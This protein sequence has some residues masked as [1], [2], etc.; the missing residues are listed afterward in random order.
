[1]EESKFIKKLGVSMPFAE[2]L[3]GSI[4][5]F[6][7][8]IAVV[9][10]GYVGLPLAVEFGKKYQTVGFDT[11]E[12]RI[13]ALEKG[14]DRTREMSASDL[15]SAGMLV[16]SN[17]EQSIRECRVYIVSVP[18]PIDHN[19]IPDLS[20][21][22]S[23]SSLVGRSLQKGDVVV[24]ESTVYPG[25]TEEV[26]VPILENTSELVFNKDFFVGYSPERI[27]PGDKAHRLVDIVKVTSGSTSEAARFVDLLYQSVISAGTY[28]AESIKVAEAAKVIENTQR[29]L[30]IALVNELSMIF[31]KQKIDTKAVLDAAASK[32]NFMRFE[33]GLVGGHCIGVDPYY[34]TYKAQQLGYKPEVILAG[35]R[36]NDSMA[37]YVV[38]L[39]VRA[40]I[41]QKRHVKG[42]R[43]LVLGIAFKENCG[44]IRNTKVIDIIKGFEDL[45]VSV[46]IFDPVVDQKDVKAEFGLELLPSLES[47]DYDFVILAVPHDE[48]VAV[49]TEVVKSI[50][51]PG[52]IIFDIKGV[53]PR[54]KVYGRL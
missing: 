27:N 6:K 54:D 43:A 53:W 17:D 19:N 1:M 29:D 24:Y 5:A 41:D 44:D 47:S 51:S 18:T 14:D 31:E 4:Q 7:S 25:A 12:S 3:F 45:D 38:D 39:V 11:N 35:R 2:E 20:Y 9:G 49:G 40:M 42:A 30:N 21:L 10:L 46:D 28:Q 23:A 36:I 13:L 48:I 50:S 15:R 16:V 34:L 33:P 52:V 37:S 26:C 32:W 22:Q 8:K